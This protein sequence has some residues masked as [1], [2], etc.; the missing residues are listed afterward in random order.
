MLQLTL[1][2]LEGL[3]D[4]DEPIVV[5]NEEHRFILAEQLREINVSAKSILLEPFGK[6]TAPAIAISALKAIE[7]EEDPILL[8][9]PA[10]HEI[11]KKE[12]FLEAILICLLYTSPSPRDR[13]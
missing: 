10:D 2:R 3:K 8:I 4:L 5:C 7:N 6:N 1:E 9:L 13:G 11:K 12:K